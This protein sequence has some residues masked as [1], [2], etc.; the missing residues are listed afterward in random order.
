MCSNKIISLRHVALDNWTYS[1]PRANGAF[2][3]SVGWITAP[4]LNLAVTPWRLW[5]VEQWAKSN[6]K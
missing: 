1:K 3:Y 4:N 2:L 6:K 5:V